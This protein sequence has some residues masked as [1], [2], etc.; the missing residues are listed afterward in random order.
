M[1]NG[2]K[3]VTLE[4]NVQTILSR[5]SEYDIFRYYMPNQHWEINR[6]TYSPFR[7]ET[8][9]SFSIYSKD[10]KLYYVDFADPNFR[11]TCFTFV[12]QLYNIDFNKALETIDRDFNLGIRI[13]PS[14]GLKFKEITQKYAQ[15]ENLEKRYAHIQVMTR[16]F[17]N[18]ELKYWNE[19]HQDISD[20]RENNIYAIKYL[21]LNKKKMPIDRNKLIFGYLYDG[22]WKI[23]RPHDPNF[24]WVPNNVPITAMDGKENLVED[25][26]VFIN[27]SKKDYMVM[28]KLYPYTCAV[29]NEGWACFSEENVDF[30]KSNSSRQILS[31][32]SDPP[33]VR[34]SKIITE[35]FGFNYCNVPRYYLQEGIKDWADLAKKYGMIVIEHY[36]KQQFIIP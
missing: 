31:F 5:I 17:N 35:M 20:L 28:K 15:P 23:Y 11:G 19:Y 3:K 4:L 10:G 21:Y 22:H 14:E 27:K 9:P 30:L 33:G 36:L 25:Q 2:E 34:N 12:M 6:A 18:D 1:I 24:K 8:K 32:D 7:N 29:Q 26:P 16:K 13:T